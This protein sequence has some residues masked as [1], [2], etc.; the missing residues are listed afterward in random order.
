MIKEK[1]SYYNE[2]LKKSPAKLVAVSKTK[3]IDDL[4]VAY[5]AGQRLFGENKVQEIMAKKEEMPADV[6][7]HMIGH[8]QRNKVKYIAPFISMIHA[9]D[10]LKLAREINKEGKKNDRQIPVLLQ[11]FIAREDTKFG[12]D[13][14]EVTEVLNQKKNGDLDN[15]LIKGLMGMATNT[16]NDDQ[17]RKE[18]AY[19]QE[20]SKNLQSTFPS[21]IG[22]ELSIGMSGDFKIAMEYGATYIRIGSDI[23]GARS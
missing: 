16:D 8:L 5:E 18:F 1:I 3:P 20:L 21:S 4:K 14:A 19:I 12:L 10:T 6:E 15:I 2:I 22:D 9:V 23:F 17:I 11:V 7:W 13:E